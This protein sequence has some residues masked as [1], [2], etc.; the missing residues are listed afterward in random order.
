VSGPAR[1]EQGSTLIEVLIAVAILALAAAGLI[2][3]LT[4]TVGSASIARQQADAQTLLISAGQAVM[5]NTL[6]PYQSCET[7]PSYNPASVISV[8]PGYSVQALPASYVYW[9]GNQWGSCTPAAQ[10]N[11]QRITI[12]VTPPGGQVGWSRQVVKRAP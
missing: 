7:S 4:T 5:D 9:D 12:T 2:G 6:I 8:P 11:L 10:G 3:G 1:S